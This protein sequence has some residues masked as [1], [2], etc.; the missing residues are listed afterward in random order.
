[1]PR[2][3]VVFTL[4]WA[5]AA[6]RANGDREEHA[7]DESGG[8]CEHRAPCSCVRSGLCGLGSGQ[9]CSLNGL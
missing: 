9:S 1:M 3:D 2:P 7:D 4:A 8:T 5:L 6:S